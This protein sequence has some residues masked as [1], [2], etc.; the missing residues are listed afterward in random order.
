MKKRT[1]LRL[2]ERFAGLMPILTLFKGVGGLASYPE[3]TA[4][5]G[6]R[7]VGHYR[8]DLLAE[9]S[10]KVEVDFELR[11]FNYSGQ[12]VAG[13]SV[14][15]T[16]L[17]QPGSAY[18]QLAQVS[19]NNQNDLTLNAPISVPR[20]EYQLW[21]DGRSPRAVLEHIDVDGQPRL[22]PIELIPSLMIGRLLA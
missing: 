12:D 20:Y 3:T 15:L 8:I 9:R 19:L 13:G 5:A 14:S 10:D 17:L 16:G 11:L 7:F 2:P 18:Q 4:K 22:E 6:L 21:M 1:R